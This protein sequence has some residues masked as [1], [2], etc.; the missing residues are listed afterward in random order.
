MVTSVDLIR[1]G[2]RM[3]IDELPIPGKEKKWMI[4]DGWRDQSRVACGIG[5]LWWVVSF[6]DVN[7]FAAWLK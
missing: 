3:C 1:R 5:G 6:C 4:V 7:D 2:E